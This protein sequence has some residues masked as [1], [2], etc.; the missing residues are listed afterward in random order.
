VLPVVSR[1]F[2]GTGKAPLAPVPR[3]LVRF[4]ASVSSLVSLEMRGLGV[5][6]LA[7]WKVAFV[8]P[9]LGVVHVG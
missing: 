1:Q 6:L 4:L 2:V 3:A 5:D 8:S 9:P 7:V